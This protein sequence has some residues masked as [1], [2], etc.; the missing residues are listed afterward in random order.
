MRCALG[1]SLGSRRYDRRRGGQAGPLLAGHRPSTSSRESRTPRS[2]RSAGSAARPRGPCSPTTTTVRWSTWRSPCPTRRPR[3]CCDTPRRRSGPPGGSRATRVPT[4]TRPVRST[5]S[6]CSRRSA[7]RSSSTPT[8]RVEWCR[9]M[10]RGASPRSGRTPTAARST[11]GS[12]TRSARRAARTDPRA[13]EALV[14][15]AARGPWTGGLVHAPP[16]AADPGRGPR[17]GARARSRGRRA[18][19]APASRVRHRRPPRRGRSGRAAGPVR[20][21]VPAPAP[22]PA[23]APSVP[24]PFTRCSP[25]SSARVNRSS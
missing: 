14:G 4:S 11:S 17:G 6:A 8:R 1:P 20:D 21:V 5:R 23:R 24:P 22:A 19:P 25:G 15:R 7:S 12:S 18:R 10:P 13:T 9:P 2:T 16:G 3:S